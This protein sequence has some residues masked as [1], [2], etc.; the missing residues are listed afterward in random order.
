MVAR[1]FVGAVKLLFAVIEIAVLISISSVI[2]VVV[3]DSAGM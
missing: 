3:K 2:V 1:F